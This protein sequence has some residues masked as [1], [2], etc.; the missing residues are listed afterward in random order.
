MIIIGYQGIGKSSISGADEGFIDLE[1]SNFWVD[2]KRNDNWYIEYSNIAKH[3]SQQGFN[4]FTSSHKLLRDEISKY[5]G[6]KIIIYPSLKLKNEWIKRV[7]DRYNKTKSDKDYKAMMNTITMY[8]ENIKDL[9]NEKSYL[10]LII[11]K[12]PYDL[13][14]LIEEYKKNIN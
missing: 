8:D 12:I 6:T 2:G 4:V 1:S 10:H 11:D 7:T 3:L 14:K 13:K 9:M 5:N